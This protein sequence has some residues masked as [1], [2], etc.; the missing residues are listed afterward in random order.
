MDSLIKAIT[1]AL[2]A[3][4]EELLGASTNHGK[5]IAILC[6]KMGKLLG[7]NAEEIIGLANCALLHDNALTESIHAERT[8]GHYDP[9]MK[10][11]CKC[12][13]RNADLLAFKTSVKDFILYHHERADG[14]GPFGIFEGE[15]PIEA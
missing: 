11:H 4:E 6:A 10:E 12:G 2:D 1:A 3:V 5:R 15:G 14:K 9:G 13:Q 8:G 7:K